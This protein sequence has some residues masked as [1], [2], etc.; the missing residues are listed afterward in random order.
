MERKNTFC[1]RFYADSHKLLELC[2]LKDLLVKGGVY[3]V[4]GEKLRWSEL[5]QQSWV[6]ELMKEKSEFGESGSIHSPSC[7]K[8]P[9]YFS[10]FRDAF[11]E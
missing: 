11:S 8:Q 6:N 5:P 7:S 3:G 1:H 9:L 2:V 4:D 10:Q